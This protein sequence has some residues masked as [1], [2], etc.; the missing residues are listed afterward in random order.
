MVV[1]VPFSY[2]GQL[3]KLTL[4]LVDGL[5][6]NLMRFI[7]SLLLLAATIRFINGALHTIRNA[8]RIHNDATMSITRRTTNG[9]D[10][11]GVAAQ[12]ALLIR[13]EDGNQRY[14]RQVQALAQQVDAYENIEFTSAQAINN[15][16]SFNSG[17]FRMQVAHPHPGLLKIFR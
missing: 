3:D 14:L 6:R 15:L 13:V 1:L 12:E 11:R 4:L 2:L 8:V 7:I 9:L 5:G 17:D 10:H 16:R